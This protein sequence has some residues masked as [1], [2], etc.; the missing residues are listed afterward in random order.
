LPLGQIWLPSIFVIKFYWRTPM[1][2]HFCMWLN[3]HV[4]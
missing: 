3:S 2:I 4:E 1:L